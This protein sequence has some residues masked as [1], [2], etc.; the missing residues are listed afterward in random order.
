VRAVANGK[1]ISA[2]TARDIMTKGIVWC[3]D[4]DD[5]THA[6]NIMLSKQILDYQS[7]I[8]TSA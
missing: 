4:T 3:R 7:S 2:L 1:N 8:R 6:A 5:V